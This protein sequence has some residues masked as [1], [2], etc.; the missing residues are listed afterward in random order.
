[1]LSAIHGGTGGTTDGS[2][3]GLAER[4]DHLLSL[5]PGK[6]HVVGLALAAYAVLEGVEAVGLWL[7]SSTA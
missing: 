1:V 4:I 6:L 7:Q 3:G 2:D 5:P